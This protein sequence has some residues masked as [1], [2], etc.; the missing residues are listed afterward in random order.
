MVH[1]YPQLTLN[2]VR[3]YG[4]QTEILIG[5]IGDESACSRKIDKLLGDGRAT[6]TAQYLKFL[7]YSYM[8]VPVLSGNVSNYLVL[9]IFIKNKRNKGLY[10]P[11][12]LTPIFKY[13]ALFK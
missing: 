10:S 11:Y 8:T 4:D 1:F 5:R 3:A 7:I 9:L 6:L 13:W 2:Q 12:D